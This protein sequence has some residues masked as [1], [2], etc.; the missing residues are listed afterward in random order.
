MPFT[1]SIVAAL[2]ALLSAN[3]LAQDAGHPAA[4]SG[5]PADFTADAKLLYRVVA[6]T[7]DSPLPPNIDAKIVEAYCKDLTPRYEKY[8]KHWIGEAEPFLKGLQASDL[9]KTVVYPFGGGDLLSALTTYP[10]ATELTTMS[11]ELAGDPRRLATLKDNERLKTSLELIRSTVAGLITANDSKSENL[12]KGQQGELPGQLAFFLIALA[13]HGYEPTGLK[14]F[15][16]NPDGSIH[17]LTEAEIANLEPKKAKHQKSSWT[18]PDFSEAFA[19]S[20]LKF[21]KHGEP[22]APVKI[23]RHFGANLDDDHMKDSPLLKHLEAKGKIVAMTKAATYLLWNDKFAVI[24]N[25]LLGH[26][27]FMVSDST[28]IPPRYAKKSG[29]VQETYGQFDGS[30]LQ[31]SPVHDV[32]NEEFRTLWSSQPERKLAFR[33]GYM[34]SNHHNHL[35][36]T[37]RAP[38]T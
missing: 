30:F 5:P 14:Y 12:M 36:V 23:H 3:A 26:M 38:K 28:G 17:Y 18:S 31:V 32:F 25:Y 15:Q 35:L 1:R 24:R 33:Y 29:F 27:E 4:A 7:G 2:V 19:F 6:C 22:N 11:L 34:D 21:V 9:P 13:I 20:E 16:L 37:K 8:R 10:D